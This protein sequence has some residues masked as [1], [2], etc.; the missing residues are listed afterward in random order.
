MPALREAALASLR[1]KMEAGTAAASKAH[2]VITDAASSVR[3]Y[4]EAAEAR[5]IAHFA[6]VERSAEA[7][8]R[9]LARVHTLRDDRLKALDSQMGE[10][11]AR[12]KLLRAGSAMC[13]AALSAK[14]VLVQAN[15]LSSAMSLSVSATVATPP[16]RP[17]RSIR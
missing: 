2:T 13:V 11:L 16:W 1:E 12:E 14:S 9:L 8:A 7:Q 17:S 6:G 10:I 5:I 4:G 3:S 15:A